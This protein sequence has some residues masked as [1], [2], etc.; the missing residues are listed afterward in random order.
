MTDATVLVVE[1]EPAIRTMLQAVLEDEGLRVIT[2]GDGIEAL[3]VVE[4]TPPAVVVTDLMM[5]RLDGWELIER[6]RT[7][8]VPVR[9]IIALSAA[10]TTSQRPPSADLFIAK[11]FDIEQVIAAVFALIA[12]TAE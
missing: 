3:R 12:P 6:L 4:S 8:R 5:P 2:A 10:A 1:D 11:P 7:A 9:G